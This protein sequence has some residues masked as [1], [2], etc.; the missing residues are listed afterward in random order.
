[1]ENKYKIK[2]S[3]DQL[4]VVYKFV[5]N[6]IESRP[7]HMQKMLLIAN[8][9]SLHK[10]MLLKWTYP[11]QVNSITLTMSEAVSFWILFNDMQFDD[12][13]VLATMT[14]ILNDIHRKYI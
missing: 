6:A 13:F 10:K 4:N 14:P 12:P 3:K 7:K 5:G 2:L 8:M 1:M 11:A 9:H